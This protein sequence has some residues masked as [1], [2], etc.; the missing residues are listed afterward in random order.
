MLVLLDLLGAPDPTFYNY[1]KNTEKWYSLLVSIEKKLAQMR[2]FESYSYGR[3]EQRYFQPYSFE[4][5]IE[6]DHIPFLEKGKYLWIVREIRRSFHTHFYYKVHLVF[7]RRA[8]FAYNTDAI[9]TL[10]AQIWRQSTQYR[11]EDYRE[12]QQDT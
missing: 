1:F 4:S 8:H 5:R 11:L 2:K 3:P 10:L 9:S 7:S 12:Y 6:D